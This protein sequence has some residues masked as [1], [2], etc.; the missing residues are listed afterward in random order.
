VARLARRAP[1]QHRY[2]APPKFEGSGSKVLHN[3]VGGIG[4]MLGSQ[5][6]L[7]TGYPIQTVMSVPGWFHEPMRLS[8]II[9][10]PQAQI[11]G[12]I[13]RHPVLQRIYNNQWV[14]LTARDPRTGD[15]HRYRPGGQWEQVVA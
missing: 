3:V 15:W 13:Q 4:V 9:E 10:A 1:L 14:H 6:D 2:S 7:Q 5:S 12:I 8:V 11:L